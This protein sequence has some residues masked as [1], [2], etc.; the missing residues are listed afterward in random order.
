MTTNSATILSKASIAISTYLTLTAFKSGT[1][2]DVT[3]YSDAKLQEYI[4]RAQAIIDTWLGSNIG[5]SS[6]KD[7]DIRCM[8]DYPKNGV[9][10]QLDKRPITEVKSIILTFCPSSTLTW[11]T[12]TKIANWRINEKI[13][14]LEYFGL[15]LS[16]YVLN[17]CLRDP[18]AGN[19]IP[20][21]E[22]IYYAGYSPIPA[23]VTRAMVILVEQLLRSEEGEDTE[24]TSV[25]IGNYREGFKRSKGIKSMGVIGGTDQVERLLRPYRQPNQSLFTNGPYG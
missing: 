1:V 22:V 17:V 7:K 9:T 16:D 21:A 12:T 20:M 24:I 19:I 6:F 5:L 4:N 15:E 2:L 14:Y 13:G 23:N 18:L 10:I 11:D 3:N 25:A 8:Y